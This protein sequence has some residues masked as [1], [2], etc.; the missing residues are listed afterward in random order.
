[1]LETHIVMS[2]LIS[3][4]VLI[5][6]FRLTRTLVLCLTLLHVLCLSSL[7]HLTIAHMV[8]VHERTTLSLD[9]LVTAHVLVVVIVFHVGLV[10]PLEGPSPTL[11]RDTWTVHAFP[12]VVHVPLT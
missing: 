7:M 9:A 10:F 12:I 11:S 5:L 6:V 1:M 2:S 4:L 3:C 8:L